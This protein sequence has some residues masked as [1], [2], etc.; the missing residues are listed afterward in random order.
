[1]KFLGSCIL[2]VGVG[3]IIGALIPPYI[4]RD[5]MVAYV[6]A[7]LILTGILTRKEAA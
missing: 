3:M 2:C 7:V 4:E 5:S 1:M 6:G